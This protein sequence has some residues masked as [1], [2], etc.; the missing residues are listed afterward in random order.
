VRWIVVQKRQ[1]RVVVKNL[2][3]A[4]IETRTAIGRK[5]PDLVMRSMPPS[6]P[7]FRAG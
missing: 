2:R 3:N 1:G 6:V 4:G 5:A 7:T